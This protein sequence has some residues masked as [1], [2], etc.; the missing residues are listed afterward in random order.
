[1]LK[2]VKRSFKV[3]L[4]QNGGLHLFFD[5]N[6]LYTK[7]FSLDLKEKRVKILHPSEP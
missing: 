3:T 6:P 5:Y 1:M 7:L 4:Q 2:K